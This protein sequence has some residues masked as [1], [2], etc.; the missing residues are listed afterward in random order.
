MVTLDTLANRAHPLQTDS[1]E[2]PHTHDRGF[3]THTLEGLE[4]IVAAHAPRRDD[5]EITGAGQFIESEIGAAHG[6]VALNG[7]DVHARHPLLPTTLQGFRDG[8]GGDIRPSPN[9]QSTVF[10]V[11]GGY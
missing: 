2:I 4:V 1:R 3:A 6:A 8:D 10:D 5:R 9:S 11:N 7:V